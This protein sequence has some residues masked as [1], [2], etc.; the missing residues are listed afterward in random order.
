MYRFPTEYSSLLWEAAGISKDRE[1]DM[2]TQKASSL[3]SFFCWR[4][5]AV[6]IPSGLQKK[7]RGSV[8]PDAVGSGGTEHKICIV[9]AA[10]CYT[11]VA[12]APKISE[13]TCYWIITVISVYNPSLPYR[14][15]P[16]LQPLADCMSTQFLLTKSP[17]PQITDFPLAAGCQAA[18]FDLLT[19]PTQDSDPSE[20][21][22]FDTSIFF[23]PTYVC[24]F[25]MIFFHISIAAWTCNWAGVPT[26]RK[27]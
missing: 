17:A 4:R 18:I 26:E 13:N 14:S 6:Q 9:I 3:C 11:A 27:A 15:I 22:H 12:V 25:Q 2:R 19:L 16:I 20:S 21:D 5:E 7:G 10:N 23:T 1:K 8:G 24:C